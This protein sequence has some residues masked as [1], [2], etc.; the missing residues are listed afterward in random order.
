M[1]KM[2][3][4]S[5][6]IVAITILLSTLDIAWADSARDP[7]KYFFENSFGDYAEELA[8]AKREGKKGVLLFF[9]MDDCPF[10]HRM[11][12]NVLNQP[13]VQDYYKQHFL[14]FAVD[15]EGQTEVV[16]FTK[17]SKIAKEFAEK[18]FR[19]RATPV[20]AFIDL[21]GKEIARYTGATSGVEEFMLLGA[22][23][24]EGH[25]ASTTFTKYKAKKRG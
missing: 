9:E 6:R 10:C 18:D 15:I 16:S 11:K 1:H 12:D 13:K 5:A 25:Y 21:N 17:Q 22:Y 7:Y 24:A 23:V 19:V 2:F 4:R 8:R 20:F 3:H 14:M